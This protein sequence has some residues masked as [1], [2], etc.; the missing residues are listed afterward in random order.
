MSVFMFIKMKKTNITINRRHKGA[1][2]KECHVKESHVNFFFTKTTPI[3]E[4]SG[5]VDYQRHS[6]STA[7]VYLAGEIT[8]KGRLSLAF[9]CKH[10]NDDDSR[11]DRALVLTL[12]L[13]TCL[14]TFTKQSAPFKLCT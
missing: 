1:G 3:D 7:G 8:S 11:N 2:V 14:S 13:K 5:R 6:A 4:I 10:G 12:C 9:A